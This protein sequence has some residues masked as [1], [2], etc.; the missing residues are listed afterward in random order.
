M[1]C[2][3]CGS[4]VLTER[5][6]L[7]AR[8]YRRLRCRTCGR[9]F[10]ERSG[11]VLNR[12]CLPRDIIAF[13]VLCRL[14]YRLTL[15][16]LSEIMALR[17]IEVS[18]EAVRDW[19][20]KLLPVLGE[21]LRRRRQ[22]TRRGS[23]ASWHVD[24]T[25][26]KVHGRWCYLYRAVDR[27]GNLVDAMLSPHCDIKA[28]KAFFRSAQATMDFRTDRVATDDH[29]SY[30]RAIRTVLGKHV[31]HRNSTY[32]NSRI[33]QGHRGIKGRIRGSRATTL[34][35]ASAASMA[36]CAICSALAAVTTKPFLPPSAASALQ[37]APE[38]RSGSSKARDPLNFCKDRSRAWRECS[39][40][41]QDSWTGAGLHWTAPAWRQKRGRRGRPKPDGSRQARHEAPPR[42]GRSR[43]AAWHRAERRQQARQHDADCHAQRRARRARQ[44]PRSAMQAPG[45]ASHR[46][47]L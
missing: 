11:G 30:P 35:T 18:Y 6:D 44:R 28:A 4:T 43:H 10:N 22:G 25:Y 32:V 2:V 3:C 19:E 37:E 8:G 9:Q 33:E 41:L 20:V 5:P 1:I 13:A 39:Q 34:P 47:G 17:G 7:T 26:L 45:Q 27:D 38:S 15:R 23:G 12:T 40:N 14:R 24:E 42:H 21:E 16:E 29:G 31:R 46:Q 36:N